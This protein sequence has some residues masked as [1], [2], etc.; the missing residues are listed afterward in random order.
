[1]KIFNLIRLIRWKILSKFL[2]KLINSLFQVN[3]CEAK[4]F[5]KSLSN[6]CCLVE[7]VILMNIED[8]N[9]QEKLLNIKSVFCLFLTKL[10]SRVLKEEKI[11]TSANINSNNSNF[12]NK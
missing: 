7:I 12:K 9:T 10:R 4:L 8:Y 5:I 2:V 11:I 1:M 6:D 3:L